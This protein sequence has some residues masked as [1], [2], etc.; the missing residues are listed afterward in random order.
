MWHSNYLTAVTQLLCSDVH[1][2]FIISIIIIPYLFISMDTIL[3]LSLS[4]ARGH[5]FSAQIWFMTDMQQ[6]LFQFS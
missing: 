1:T 5:I 2:I 4:F 3:F 6:I